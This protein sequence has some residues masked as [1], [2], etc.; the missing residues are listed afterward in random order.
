MIAKIL[1][2]AH[3]SGNSEVYNNVWKNTAASKEIP[4]EETAKECI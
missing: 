2:L 4:P 3:A 1:A